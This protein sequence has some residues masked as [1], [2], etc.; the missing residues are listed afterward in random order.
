[1]SMANLKFCLKHK[2]D[3]LKILHVYWFIVH[4]MYPISLQ[5][6]RSANSRSQRMLAKHIFFRQAQVQ[7]QVRWGSGEGQE[8]QSQAKS[9]SENSK[10]KDLDLSSTL[11]LVFTT[12]PPVTFFLALEG[13]G[14]VRWT[15]D[16]L[17]WLK[18]GLRRSGLPGGHQ[19]RD[20]VGLQGGH[21]GV[22]Q[23]V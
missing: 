8:G 22:L 6:S 10:M 1:M 19:G 18:K 15:Y 20:Q 12:H 14:H 21:Q 11:F 7:V 23:W 13:T 2:K 3:V 4:L 17:V 5:L 9:S 16:G